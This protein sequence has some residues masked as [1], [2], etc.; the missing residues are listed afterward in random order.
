M[1]GANLNG[2]WG[3][4]HPRESVVRTGFTENTISEPE[5]KAAPPEKAPHL[6]YLSEPWYERPSRIRA[7]R[8]DPNY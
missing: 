6:L 5:A 7:I 8:D 2:R 4:G 1:R 3:N